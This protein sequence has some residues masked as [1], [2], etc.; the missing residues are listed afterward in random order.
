MLGIEVQSPVAERVYRCCIMLRAVLMVPEVRLFVGIWM[1]QGEVVV[2]SVPS[3]GSNKVLV[4]FR[5]VKTN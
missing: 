5:G 4:H 3:V 2:T 1:Q